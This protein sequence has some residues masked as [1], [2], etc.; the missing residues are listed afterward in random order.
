MLQNDISGG[1][2]IVDLW[3][4]KCSDLL[5]CVNNSSV[6][7]CEYNCDTSYEDL[8]VTAEEVTDVIKKLDVNKACG[9]DGVYSEHMKYL[10]H[11]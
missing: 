1:K 4:K 6:D 3:R 9:P 2:E 5:N 7:T 10:C 11:C 8:D